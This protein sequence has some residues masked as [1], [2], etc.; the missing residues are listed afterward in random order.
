M[1]VNKDSASELPQIN[2][3]NNSHK[4]AQINVDTLKKGFL[5]ETLVIGAPGASRTRG[6]QFAK[7]IFPLE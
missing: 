5:V 4:K 6:T 7:N 1:F 2:F 3:R